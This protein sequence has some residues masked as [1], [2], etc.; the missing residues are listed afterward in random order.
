MARKSTWV[1][2]LVDTTV[3]NNG[4][5]QLSL[6]GDLEAN[7]K[8]GLTLAR[9]IIHLF[10]LPAAIGIADGVQTMDLGIGV[11]EPD[12]AVAGALPDVDDAGDQPGRGWVW[13]DR[14]IM[15]D[16]TP[17][18]NFYI[19]IELKYDIRSMRVLYHN[20]LLLIIDSSPQQGVAFT[21]DLT[22][23]IRCMFLQ[24]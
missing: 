13:R 17:A 3:S 21:M 7:E 4:Q 15:V 20:T 2:T 22:G 6:T 12:A 1:D 24:P 16:E 11:I 8:R 5:T 10:G 9:T 18:E 23:I 19:P 14:I